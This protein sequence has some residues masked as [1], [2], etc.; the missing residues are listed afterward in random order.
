VAVIPAPRRISPGWRSAI[1]G[2]DPDS[3]RR[4]TGQSVMAG[5]PPWPRLTTS[6]WSTT[7][8]GPSSTAST[9]RPCCRHGGTDGAFSPCPSPTPSSAR[10]RCD[11]HRPR[12][13]LWRA[14]TPQAFR[15]AALNAA[16][17]AGPTTRRRRRRGVIEAAGGRVRLSPATHAAQADLSGGFRD[18]RTAGGRG[19]ITARARASTP[20][21]SAPRRSRLCASRYPPTRR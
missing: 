7:P 19:R 13:G 16:Y 9:S 17:A 3:R 5:S 1:C 14:Q 11:R 8:R 4:D 12:D 10:R 18:G 2:T 20:T 6:S 21:A 15:T